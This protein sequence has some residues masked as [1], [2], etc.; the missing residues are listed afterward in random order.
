MLKRGALFRGAKPSQ[1]PTMLSRFDALHFGS[2]TTNHRDLRHSLDSSRSLNHARL[3][4]KA[5]SRGTH[6]SQMRDDAR[7]THALDSSSG[8]LVRHRFM[9]V[10]CVCAYGALV[11]EERG[12]LKES[13]NMHSAMMLLMRFGSRHALPPAPAS[14]EQIQASSKRASKH[15]SAALAPSSLLLLLVLLLRSLGHL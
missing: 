3:A 8:V 6:E 7:H 4:T 11:L 1:R 9:R 13:P 2:N 14:C 10:V 5:R 15:S 12:R